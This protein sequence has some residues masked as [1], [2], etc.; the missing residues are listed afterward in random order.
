MVIPSFDFDNINLSLLSCL[1]VFSY[2]KLILFESSIW[3]DK[4]WLILIIVFFEYSSLYFFNID[5]V[6]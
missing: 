6:I 4:F 3:N 2:R 5:G 1:G